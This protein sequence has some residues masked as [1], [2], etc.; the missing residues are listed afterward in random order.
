MIDYC[1]CKTPDFARCNPSALTAD[2]VALLKKNRGWIGKI[3]CV[4]CGNEPE[5]EPD[6]YWNGLGD[7]L[8]RRLVDLGKAEALCN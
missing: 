7:V 8:I 3:V 2:G 6:D 5:A 1:T 4:H